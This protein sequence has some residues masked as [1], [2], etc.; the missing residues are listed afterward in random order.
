MQ[1]PRENGFPGLCDVPSGRGW[2]S[3]NL[4]RKSF[5]LLCIAEVWNLYRARVSLMRLQNL[6]LCLQVLGLS[7]LIHAVEKMLR[8]TTAPSVSLKGCSKPR[9]LPHGADTFHDEW[10]SSCF[11]TASRYL[12]WQFKE[13]FFSLV[14]HPNEREGGRPTKTKQI[15]KVQNQQN[16]TFRDI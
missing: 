13:W 7:Y 3:R 12:D 8:N 5:W 2:N 10:M 9:P 11:Q 6:I 1:R 15:K 16:H 14:P 4:H